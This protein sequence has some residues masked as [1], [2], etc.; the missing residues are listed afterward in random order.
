VGITLDVASNVAFLE[1]WWDPGSHDQAED[2]C[3]GRLSDPHGANAWYLVALGTIEEEIAELLDKKRKVID[4]ILD[5]K[6][7]DNPSVLTEL[8]EAVKEKAYNG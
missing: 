1:F 5:G 7:I 4:S 3:Y 8:I 2:R 6:P